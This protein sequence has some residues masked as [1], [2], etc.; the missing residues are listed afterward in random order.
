MGLV[1][2]IT[3]FVCNLFGIETKEE[4]AKQKQE[5]IS[6]QG[7]YSSMSEQEPTSDQEKEKKE[8]QWADVSEPLKFVCQVGKAQCTF[9]NPPMADIIVTSSTIMLQD[10]PWASIKDKDG[11]VNFNFTGVCTHPS[12]QKPGAPPPPCKAVIS[13]GEWKDF[14]ETMVGNNN[15]LL[16]Q[17]TI[18]C[19]ISGQDLK[20]IDSGQRAELSELE[21]KIEKTPRVREIYWMD[22]KEEKIIKTIDKGQKVVMIAVTE[23]F[24]VDDP[25]DFPIRNKATKEEFKTLKGTVNSEG[26]VKIPWTY[27]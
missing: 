22:E 24:E 9:S 4:K 18:P 3:N 6:E 10:K 19:M 13:L 17:S 11:K 23:D 1:S 8:E 27:E 15:A 21:P 16:V 14:S 20:I 12:Q 2:T 26:L 25:L 5:Q 7:S